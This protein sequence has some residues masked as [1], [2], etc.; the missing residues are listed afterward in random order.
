[1]VLLI[2]YTPRE[3]R[4]NGDAFKAVVN[5]V[6]GLLASRRV[7]CRLPLAFFCSWSTNSDES[8]P[9]TGPH[10]FG[11][12]YVYIGHKILMKQPHDCSY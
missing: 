1:M 2:H 10:A 7:F 8:T 9:L 6:G 4:V 3:W 11:P 5:T 12:K